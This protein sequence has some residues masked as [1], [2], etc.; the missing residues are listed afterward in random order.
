MLKMH[1]QTMGKFSM[2]M[3]TRSAFKQKYFD[4]Q[5]NFLSN[6]KDPITK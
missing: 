5:L 6:E 4:Q 1:I 3:L 2:K